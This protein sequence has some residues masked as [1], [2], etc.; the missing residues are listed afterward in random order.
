MWY[1]VYVFLFVNNVRYAY[2]LLIIFVVLCRY[3]SLCII[4]CCCVSLC[5]IV[6]RCVLLYVVLGVFICH[7]VSS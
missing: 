1:L 7:Y 3:M 4:V 5:V 6:C 2:Y